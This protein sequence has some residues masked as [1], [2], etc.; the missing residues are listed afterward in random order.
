MRFPRSPKL[1]SLLL[2]LAMLWLKGCIPQRDVN[3][4]L[5]TVPPVLVVESYA[6][7]DS[8]LRVSVTQTS[9]Y[10]S[11]LP[12]DTAGL[13]AFLQGQ[14][15]GKD[16]ADVVL[17]RSSLDGTTV[18][19][20]D[21][22]QYYPPLTAGNYYAFG[23][24]R[25]AQPLPV[26]YTS[27]FTLTVKDKRLKSEIPLEKRTV[28]AST[29]LLPTIE[30]DSFGVKKSPNG[31]DDYSAYAYWTD[32]HPGTTDYYRATFSNFKADS[33]ASIIFSDQLLTKS[34]VAAATTYFYR[35]NETIDIRVYNVS[36]AYYDFRRS[37][38]RAVAA[39]SNPFSEPTAVV[40]N[41]TNGFGIFT[42]VGVSRRSVFIP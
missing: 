9:A 22:L 15:I 32:P 31:K 2:L 28:F 12:Q 11:V 26:D 4:P 3:I 25:T 5:P 41:V 42:G 24:F 20:R 30:I 14:I 17:V 34:Q 23:E 35:P 19:S 37:A 36:K 39:N 38:N 40:S 16:S 10:F 29:Q 13:I 6:Y 33:S 1:P 21:T 7:P 27:L 8:I 18:Y